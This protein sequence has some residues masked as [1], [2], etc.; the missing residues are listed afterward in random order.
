MRLLE[1]PV[2]T[3][4][5]SFLADLAAPT[6][7]DIGAN[8]GE[9][10][11][12][13]LRQIPGASVHAFEPAAQ[14]FSLL[15]SFADDE[16]RVFAHHAA[17]GSH[18]GAAT[19]IETESDLLS[20]VLPLNGIGHSHFGPCGRERA[21]SEVRCVRLDSWAAEQ[22]IGRVDF[23]KLD[24]QGSELEVLKGAESLLSSGVRA[25][26]SEAQVVAE[27]EGAATLTDLDLFLRDRGFVL[28]QIQE[29]RSRGPEHQTSDVDALWVRADILARHRDAL[30]NGGREAELRM[31]AALHRLAEDGLR[32]VAVYGAGEHT[33]RAAAALFDPPVEVVAIIDDD[34]KREG[35]RAWG[36]PVI[37]LER[38]GDLD[39][40]AVVISS[41]A[42]EGALGERAERT[43]DPRVRVVRLYSEGLTERSVVM[44]GV[45]HANI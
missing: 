20:S 27:Y 28:H 26:Y 18:D 34:A 3:I 10:V 44:Q 6:L 32:R 23:I 16:P 5:R 31:G 4:V 36:H 24:V 7:L 30:A 35:S 37:P 13:M 33:R 11:R 22:G 9:E 8:R 41:D 14:C 25:V 1:T 38:A 42:Y 45:E 12:A 21:R 19:L 40:D 2:Y 43:L 17:V 15:S 39:L 29:V